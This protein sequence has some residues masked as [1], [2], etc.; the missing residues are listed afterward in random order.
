MKIKNIFKGVPVSENVDYILKAINQ[1]EKITLFNRK[2][3]SRLLNDLGFY[4]LSNSIDCSIILYI[5]LV[6]KGWYISQHPFL[7]TFL[8]IS[9]RSKANKII[10]EKIIK[11][12]NSQNKV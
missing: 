6:L 11:E 10:H 4:D 8:K 7:D 12:I 5:N 9:L 1:Y 2:S 3:I